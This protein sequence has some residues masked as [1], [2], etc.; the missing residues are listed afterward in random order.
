M[1]LGNVININNNNNSNL[2]WARVVGAN[3]M[4]NSSFSFIVKNNPKLPTNLHAGGISWLIFLPLS[5]N[6]NNV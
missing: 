5:G 6:D 4:C 3:I 2:F 1:Q